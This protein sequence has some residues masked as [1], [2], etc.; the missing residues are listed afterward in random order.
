MDEKE[1]KTIYGSRPEKIIYYSP[2]DSRKSYDRNEFA[3]HMD[4]L[5][6]ELIKPYE[7]I[8][9]NENVQY[10]L[11]KLGRKLYRDGSYFFHQKDPLISAE[12]EGYE[13]THAGKIEMGM[14]VKRNIDTFF[15]KN[16]AKTLR[17][18]L[19]SVP[20]TTDG[21]GWYTEAVSDIEEFK[22]IMETSKD[23]GKISSFVAQKIQNQPFWIKRIHESFGGIQ[24]YD[25]RLF[26]F[27]FSY[28][29]NKFVEATGGKEPDKN[30]I[31]NIL[32]ISLDI[33]WKA[34]DEE[35]D[36][37]LYDGD[38]GDIYEQTMLPVYLGLA[39]GIFKTEYEE[40]EREE[41]LIKWEREE[42]RKRS[43]VKW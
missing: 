8:R 1:A 41:E 36:G 17:E 24:E 6:N 30:K 18:L 12:K 25:Q 2:I 35:T 7:R 40:R 9:K 34:F 4:Y 19:L 14:Y 16:N 3:Y 32:K 31:E 29:Q 33:G 20:L 23:A 42:K 39:N 26:G 21:Q 5:Y 28:Y 38:K 11:G 27:Y 15:E 37:N 10:N 13:F 22:G 43:N